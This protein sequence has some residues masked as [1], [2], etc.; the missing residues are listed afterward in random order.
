LKGW[1]NKKDRWLRE[2]DK[3]V[4]TDT[5][6]AELGF[7]VYDNVLRSLLTPAGKAAGWMV[8]MEDGQWSDQP[9]S[10]VKMVLQHAS[11]SK[12]EAEAAMGGAVTRAW[13]LV[14]LPFH[15]EYPGGRQWNIDAAQFQFKPAEPT[16]GDAH[17]PHW[18]MIFKHIGCDLDAAIHEAPWAQR[19]GIRNGAQYLLLWVA[20]MF[21]DPFEP[22]PYLFM[23]GGENCGKSIFHEALALLVTKGVVSADRTLAT[24]NDFNGELA[25]AILCVVEE[26][27]VAA[28]PRAHSRIKEWVTCRTLSIRRMRTDSYSQPNTSHWVQCA[29]RQDHCPVFPNDTRIT[30]IH[31]P[32]LLKDQEVPKKTMLERLREE[33]PAFMATMLNVELPPVESRLRLPVVETANKLTSEEFSRDELEQF[34][35]ENCFYAPG[36]YLTFKDFYDKFY[37]WLPTDQRGQWNRNRCA[38]S[39]PFKYPTWFGHANKKY[40][41]NISFEEPADTT[42]T[43]IVVVNGKRVGEAGSEEAL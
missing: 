43:P 29:N 4:D 6:T 37:E 23:F 30:V 33:A 2:Y 28:S 38:R 26:R 13:K 36:Q 21:R 18:D 27:N 17:H 20:C 25:N 12:P 40:I 35:S 15:D 11:A 41:G 8:K 5:D 14:N 42:A 22:L 3:T 31:V 9:L 34:I 10:N 16:E 1:V 32:D 7:E 39:I 19:M 24:G